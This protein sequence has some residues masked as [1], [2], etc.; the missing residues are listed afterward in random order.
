MTPP[1]RPISEFPKHLAEDSKA[2]VIDAFDAS[3]VTA[4]ELVASLIKN[5]GCVMRGVLNPDQLALIEKDVRPWIEK[6]RPWKGDFFPPETRRVMGL[7]EKSKAFTDL[8]PGNCLFR[9]VCDT[10]LI[11][12]H[13]S[14]LGQTLETSVLKP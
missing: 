7:V 3:T 2:A 12:T 11:S 4:P 9:D 8:I 10:L 14:W 13:E 5:G 6:D 1:D